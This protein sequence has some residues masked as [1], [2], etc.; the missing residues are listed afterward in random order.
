M[1]L[2]GDRG[3]GSKISQETWETTLVPQ[4]T[5]LSRLTIDVNAHESSTTRHGSPPD[6]TTKGI[7]RPVSLT[8]NWP[9]LHM[10]TTHVTKEKCLLGSG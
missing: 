3:I 9:K 6:Q 4:N 1:F 8:R 7:H 5:S 10:P 2:V